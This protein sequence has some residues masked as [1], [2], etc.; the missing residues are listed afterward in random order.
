ME[1][2]KKISSLILIVILIISLFL[3]I[4]SC[5]KVN[6]DDYNNIEKINRNLQ[7]SRDSLIMVNRKLDNNFNSIQDSINKRDIIILKLNNDLAS[8]QND[9][10]NSMKE[11]NRLKSQSRDT[12][13][14]IDN[15][16]KNPIIR[17]DEDL[18]KS[19]KNKLK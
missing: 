1:S 9:L 10:D 4:K 7:S 11:L 13:K 18:I 5:N 14:K 2:F 8:A 12:E 16:V 3:N 19:L 6:S 15:L 17:S